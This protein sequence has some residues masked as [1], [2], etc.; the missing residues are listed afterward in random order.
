[1]E[2]AIAFCMK[3]HITNSD[4]FSEIFVEPLRDN[5]N[6]K[7]YPWD[8]KNWDSRMDTDKPLIFFQYP[9]HPKIYSNPKARVVWVPMWDHDVKYPAAGWQETPKTLK[10]LAYSKAIAKKANKLKLQTMEVKYYP[11]PERYQPIDWNQPRRMFYWNR[12][13]IISPNFLEKL[14]QALDV[15]ELIFRDQVDP[16][17]HFGAKFEMPSQFGNTKVK[18]IMNNLRKSEYLKLIH[19]A[20]IFIAPRLAEGVGVFFIEGLV[21]GSAVFGYNAPTMNEYIEHKKNGF[22]LPAYKLNVF[23]LIQY[24]NIKILH[25]LK[26]YVQGKRLMFDYHVSEFQ[27]WHEIKAIDIENLG[28]EARKSG[29]LGFEE[30]QSKIPSLAKFILDW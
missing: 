23:N 1:M 4:A 27:N 26:R 11:N 3:W 14:C 17:T 28:K 13:G 10:I 20:N 12:R 18:K 16:Y 21:Q 15:R 29:I 7:L 5:L 30:W 6:V 8:G 9:P 24:L 2:K 19:D 22:L 25:R